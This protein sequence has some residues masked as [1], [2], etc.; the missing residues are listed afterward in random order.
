VERDGFETSVPAERA[1]G[2]NLYSPISRY[3]TQAGGEDHNT[4]QICPAALGTKDQQRAAFSPKAGIFYVPTNHVCVDYEP[5]K[6]SYNNAP[7]L[8]CARTDRVVAADQPAG[9]AKAQIPRVEARCEHG[10]VTQT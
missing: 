5:F 8:C 7:L 9:D 4:R 10:R 3:S 1:Y 2:L 6:V